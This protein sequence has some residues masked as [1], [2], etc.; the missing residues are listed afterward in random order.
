VIAD[1]SEVLSRSPENIKVLYRRALA[2][3]AL[4]QFSE[5][6]E[7]IQR[8]LRQEPNHQ[9]ALKTKERLQKALAAPAPLSPRKAK[10]S[11]TVASEPVA[12]SKE[13]Q[14]GGEDS[15]W[16]LETMKKEALQ[17]LGNGAV[18]KAI[19]VLQNALSLARATDK[20][21]TDA[22]QILSLQQLLASAYASQESYGP[23]LETA[24]EILQKNPNNFKALL[25]AG[26]SAFHLVS[27]FLFPPP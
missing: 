16:K 19:A 23:S 12:S 21:S 25:R 24:E 27:L 7:D 18:P 3:E 6:Q 17:Y 14:G 15:A 5:C 22:D 13:Q 26:D 10:A 20:G 9:L 11:V 4:S 8:I 1:S 2:Y